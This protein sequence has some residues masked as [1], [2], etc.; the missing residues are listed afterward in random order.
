MSTFKQ[1]YSRF[2]RKYYDKTSRPVWPPSL[3]GVS[4]GDF[5]HVID[6]IFVPEGNI[7]NLGLNFISIDDSDPDNLSI[8][9]GEESTIDLKFSGET[10]AKLPSIPQGKAGIGFN[11][12]KKGA[13][14][15]EAEKSY[16][17]RIGNLAEL[18][19]AI[20]KLKDEKKWDTEWRVVTSLIQ[21]ESARFFLSQSSNSSVELTFEGVLTPSISELGKAGADVKITA[22][23]NA[24]F[25]LNP[26]GAMTPI[27]HLH[28]LKGK[29][30]GGSDFEPF[31]ITTAA[32]AA[33]P[34]VEFSLEPDI[35]VEL[36][37]DE[38]R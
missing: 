14:V 7:R 9:T 27:V 29:L 19:E 12:G 15:L 18:G 32:A 16:V 22:K 35:S 36:N 1:Q 8:V 23:R 24:V 10:N 30:L 31:K 3:P 20:K 34:K 37:I 38:I 13:F 11:F 6:D 17:P 2:L 33:P 26:S 21:V 5:G 28:R 4:L 25:V